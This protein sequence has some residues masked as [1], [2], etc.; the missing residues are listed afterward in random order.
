M[1]RLE[2]GF[3]A[4]ILRRIRKGCM[5]GILLGLSILTMAQTPAEPCRSRYGTV[6]CN[7]CPLTRAGSPLVSCN[8]DGYSALCL[9]ED[10]G[11]YVAGDYGSDP[12]SGGKKGPIK[13]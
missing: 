1:D 11:W 10:G 3:P 6:W 8:A 9:Y 2:A 13:K 4:G 5:L 12:G 7:C